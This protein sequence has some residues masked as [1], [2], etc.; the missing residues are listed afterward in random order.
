MIGTKDYYYY[1]G[2]QY[3]IFKRVE[4]VTMRFDDDGCK[5]LR[6][7]TRKVYRS[8]KYDMW[9][10]LDNGILVPATVELSS[11]YLTFDERRMGN[12]TKCKDKYE[13]NVEF[14]IVWGFEFRVTC[15]DNYCASSVW[16]YDYNKLLSDLQGE[17]FYLRLYFQR[18]RA[19]FLKED[20]FAARISATTC[21][22][23]W[24][25]WKWILLVILCVLILILVLLVVNVIVVYNRRQRR[26]LPLSTDDGEGSRLVERDPTADSYVFSLNTFDRIQQEMVV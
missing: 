25:V 1:Y 5:N 9:E 7:K 17:S 24:S 18:D 23:A 13:S 3:K 12:T 2:E 4:I 19:T 21:E 11:I 20:L 14:N 16:D 10:K 26:F 8:K 15:R 22:D 6:M